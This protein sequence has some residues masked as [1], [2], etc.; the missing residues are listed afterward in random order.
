MPVLYSVR[1]RSAYSHHKMLCIVHSARDLP[2]IKDKYIQAS[3]SSIGT[4]TKTR[5][6][7]L[8]HGVEGLRITV[9]RVKVYTERTLSYIP[10]LGSRTVIRYGYTLMPQ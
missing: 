2:P 3:V 10:G 5:L 8:R 1:R 4:A 7:R 9:E 6:H